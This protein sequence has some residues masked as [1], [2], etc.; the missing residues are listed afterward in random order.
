MNFNGIHKMCREG[1]YMWAHGHGV[2]GTLHSLVGV[3]TSYSIHY[4]KLYEPLSYLQRSSAAQ[5]G[6]KIAVV[7]AVGT[8]MRGKSHRQINPLTGVV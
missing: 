8:I 5:H 3:I 1:R 4:T 7:T 6:P 2:G